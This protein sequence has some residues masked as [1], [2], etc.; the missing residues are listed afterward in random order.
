MGSNDRHL[1]LEDLKT[2]INDV[3]D[4]KINELIRLMSRGS[5]KTKIS[6]EDFVAGFSQFSYFAKRYSRS[7]HLTSWLE[8]HS[9]GGNAN[10]LLNSLQP[11]PLFGFLLI[12]YLI[13]ILI[14]IFIF[15]FHI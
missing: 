8:S 12:L 14:L 6:Q 9:Q 1:R 10:R 2:I 4:E 13:L 7:N 15:G 11:S 5:D 3:N